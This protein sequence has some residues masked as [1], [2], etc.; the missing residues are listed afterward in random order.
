M[1]EARF[2]PSPALRAPGRQYHVPGENRVVVAFRWVEEINCICVMLLS[3]VFKLRRNVRS[4]P[5]SRWHPI[6]SRSIPL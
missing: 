3:I 1:C 2:V 6:D 5:G 4:H